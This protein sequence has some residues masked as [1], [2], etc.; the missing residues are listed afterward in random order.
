MAMGYLAKVDYRILCDNVDW[1]NMN[2]ISKKK[3]TIRDLNKRL[4]L[5]QRDE[6]VI[7]EIQKVVQDVDNPRIAIFSPSIEHSNRFAVMLSAAGIPC[8]ALSRVD[9]AERR[10]RLLAFTSGTYQAVTAVDIMNE[11]IDI[12]D[13]VYKKADEYF[14]SSHTRPDNSAFMDSLVIDVDV[15]YVLREYMDNAVIRTYIKDSILNAYSKQRGKDILSA[16]SATDTVK[17]LFGIDTSVIQ[18]QKNNNKAVSVCRSDDGKI[19]VVSE[20]TVLKWETALRKALEII[21]REPG[22]SVDG[23]SQSICLQLADISA[24]ITDGDKKHI[25]TALAAISVK[26]RFCGG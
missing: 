3:L 18:N 22:L 23:F 11:G 21:A 19:F 1:D 16:E 20:G 5:P 13:V 17:Q 12:P 25:S 7:A 14:Y 10:R 2:Q 9:K 15:G 24:S 4:F 8:A 26:A 6:A